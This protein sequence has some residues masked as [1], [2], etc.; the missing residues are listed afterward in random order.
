MKHN[1]ED[2]FG[3]VLELT[4]IRTKSMILVTKKTM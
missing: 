2:I 3:S 1:D 4:L